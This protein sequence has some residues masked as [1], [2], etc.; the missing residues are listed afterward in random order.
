MPNSDLSGIPFTAAQS[1]MTPSALRHSVKTGD[2]DRL[3]LGVYAK[4]QSPDP[5]LYRT[6]RSTNLRAAQGAAAA[7]D[8]AAISHASATIASGLPVIGRAVNQ[9]CVT[10][11]SGTALRTLAK[12]HLH[13]ATL[14]ETIM[15][16][17]VAATPVARTVCDLA[18]EHGVAAGLAAADAALHLGLTSS[19]ELVA[20]AQQQRRW[21]GGRAAGWVAGF[22]DARIESALESLSRLCMHRYNLPAP[23]PQARIVDEHG[24]IVARADFYYDEFGV[25]GE[26]DGAMKWE[27][28]PEQRDK[29]DQS[30]HLLEGLGLIVVRWG[31]PDLRTFGR[32][33]RRFKLGFARGAR[34]GSPLRRWDVLPD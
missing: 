23:R 4:A 34:P 11:Q 7:C 20:V 8:R 30:T 14:E 9:P 6:L 25:M 12:A 18:R 5:L 19:E 10:V 21:P 24:V 3:Q 28:D 1:G 33:V 13:R 22:A 2:Y 31:W 15:I 29:R 16:N 32:V 17:G 27:N 26:S